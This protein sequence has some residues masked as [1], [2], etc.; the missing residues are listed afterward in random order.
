[1]NRS[2]AIISI[3][4][5][6]A[7]S[8]LG[9]G[10]AKEAKVINHPIE[11]P[12]LLDFPVA[13]G[14]NFTLLKKYTKLFMWRDQF[15]PTDVQNII[16]IANRVDELD[17]E[18]LEI[19]IRQIAPL[20]A[21]LKERQRPFDEAI[22][23]LNRQKSE[24]DTQLRAAQQALNHEKSLPE[25]Q[26]DPAKIEE[27]TRLIA[28]LQARKTEINGLIRQKQS[29][30]NLVGKDDLIPAIE[31]LEKKVTE[32]TEEGKRQNEDLQARVQWFNTQ[33][34]FLFGRHTHEDG[35]EFYLSI[36]NWEMDPHSTELFSFSTEDRSIENF[37]YTVLGG[38]MEF[39]VRHPTLG[40]FHFKIARSDYYDIDQ[41][42]Q[43]LRLQ[44]NQP[45][46]YR[47]E[48]TQ[49]LLN[50]EVKYGKAKLLVSPE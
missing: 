27:L 2:L 7:M 45:I 30:R 12:P 20:T 23:D 42:T 47:G 35:G 49:T 44:P 24:I 26:Q 6:I 41:Q 16:R 9:C 28:Q 15:S 48:I 13:P 33:P 29:E 8:A 17:E 32:L 3:T 37:Q 18:V 34:T 43:K 38:V 11:S 10:S 19:Q 21:E 25:P 46:T 39:E 31:D 50:G 22:A 5:G 4:L 36:Q 40:T 14:T 1:M